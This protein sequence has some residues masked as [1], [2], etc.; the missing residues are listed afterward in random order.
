MNLNKKG[1]NEGL[2]VGNFKDHDKVPP[3][4][5]PHPCPPRLI[6]HPSMRSPCF[7][8]RHVKDHAKD[9]F[10]TRNDLSPRPMTSKR[11]VHSCLTQP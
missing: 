8:A 11:R 6:P 1:W 3:T 2:K 7:A 10:A 4:P 9:R 5:H